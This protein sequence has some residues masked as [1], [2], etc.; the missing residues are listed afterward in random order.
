M[1]FDDEIGDLSL[2][3]RLG[4]KTAGDWKSRKIVKLF[5]TECKFMLHGKCNKVRVNSLAEV[6]KDIDFFNCSQGVS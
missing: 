2:Q 4:E 3:R 5:T 6:I 1:K